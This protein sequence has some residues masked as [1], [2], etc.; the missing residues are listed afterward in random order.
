[1]GY[2]K[3]LEILKE[4][5]KNVLLSNQ[6]VEPL[7]SFSNRQLKQLADS[8]RKRAELLRDLIDWTI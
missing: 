5:P 7:F 2:Y 3:C 1:M 6:H 4:L 8:I